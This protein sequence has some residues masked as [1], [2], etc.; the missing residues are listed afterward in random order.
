M[1]QMME[2]TSFF[3]FKL[4]LWG[5]SL[6]VLASSGSVSWARVMVKESPD[7]KFWSSRE[8]TGVQRSSKEFKGVRGSITLGMLRLIN[9]NGLA[10]A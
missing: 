10:E 3:E 8:F 1:A 9:P 5:T 4:R 2:T 6:T 7:A